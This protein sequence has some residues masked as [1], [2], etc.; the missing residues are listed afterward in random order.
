[1]KNKKRK[2]QRSSIIKYCVTTVACLLLFCVAYIY[3]V[4][5]TDVVINVDDQSSYNPANF[6]RISVQHIISEVEDNNP[7]INDP[8]D[9]SGNNPPPGVPNPGPV[10]PIPAD[11]T[12]KKVYKFLSGLGYSDTMCAGIM[13]NIHQESSMSFGAVQKHADGTSTDWTDNAFCTACSTIA[14]NGYAHGLCQWDKG[15]LN[16]LLQTAAANGVEWTDANFQFQYM[17]SEITG[18]YYSKWCDPNNLMN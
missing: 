4:F 13:G 16:V 5:G 6:D 17:E 11:E 10:N 12:V 1:M 3:L 9:G 15:R 7:G 2:E 8:D 14:S 18:S